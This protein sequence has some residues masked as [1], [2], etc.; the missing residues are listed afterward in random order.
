MRRA[1]ESHGAGQSACALPVRQSFSEWLAFYRFDFAKVL[2]EPEHNPRSADLLGNCVKAVGP[3]RQRVAPADNGMHVSGF[4][5]LPQQRENLILDARTPGSNKGTGLPAEKSHSDAVRSLYLV[6]SR[7]PNFLNSATALRLDL[8]AESGACC[9]K[10]PLMRST[11]QQFSP[12]PRIIALPN[13]LKK[14]GGWRGDEAVT[15]LRETDST[16]SAA[17]A[18]TDAK[19]LPR[20]AKSLQPP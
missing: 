8:L 9:E 13:P 1:E 4:L 14:W 20:S 5:G 2:V 15:G 18:R 10:N 12:L 3:I 17:Y 6:P 7:T 16:V 11:M 19:E